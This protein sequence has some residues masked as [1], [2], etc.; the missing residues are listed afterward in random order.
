MRTQDGEIYTLTRSNLMLPKGTYEFKVYNNTETQESYPS[1]NASLEI[2]EDAV[3]N[4]LFNFNSST[5]EVTATATKTD[6]IFYNY[7]IKGKIAEVIQNP[8]KYKGDII[9]PEKV[10]HEGVEYTVTKIAD[11]AFSGCNLITSISIPNTVLSIGT[12]AFY[13]CNKL[14]S[15]TIP[16]SVTTIGSSAF[17][18]CSS[19]TSVT[20]SDLEAW[21]KITFNDNPLSYAHRLFLNG[22]EIK[23]LVIPNTVTSISNNAFRD[24][25]GLTSV[26]IPNSITSFGNYVFQNCVGLTSVNIENGLASIVL[27]TFSGCTSLTSVTI[28]NSISS[29]GDC[30]F[31]GC[32]GL[33]NLTIPNSVMS[34]G[35]YAFYDCSGLASVTL[36]SNLT[37]IA[38]QAFYQCSSLTSVNIPNSVEKIGS[39]AFSGC[40]GLTSVTVGS[41]I[42]YIN[43]LAFANCKNLEDFYCLAENVPST[44]ADAFDNSYVQYA[45]LHVPASASNVYTTTAPWSGFGIFETLSGE[46]IETKKC[47]TPTISF[48]DGK[49]K[50]SCETE[51]V[52]FV[53][54]VSTTDTK[55][56]YD[57]ELT[58]TYKYKVKVYATKSGYENSDTAT[59]EIE[60]PASLRGDVNKDGTVKV[61]D[62]VELTKIIMN[63]E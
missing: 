1:S 4:V 14:T 45:T 54:N 8:N 16:S 39:Q 31:Q 46:S 25:T 6:G 63:E 48:E 13:Q 29:I 33:T 26:Y 11:H 36:P 18:G 58:L 7:I 59:A 35:S 28:P 34:I 23:D 2:E 52:E 3:Y 38:I 60:V 55:D 53:S 32:K 51:G 40:S 57:A 5:K 27:G 44:L 10:T 37:S 50:F 12:C 56:Y 20:I 21:C 43:S 22:E 15:V 49:I 17:Y 24:C 62:H 42:N 61:A 30:A 47:A 41:G 19:L 9:I